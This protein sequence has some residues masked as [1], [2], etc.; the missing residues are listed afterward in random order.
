MISF[1]TGNYIFFKKSDA[2]GKG[3]EQF[4]QQKPN[5]NFHKILNF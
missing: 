3:K 5:L 2:L 4:N 1:S